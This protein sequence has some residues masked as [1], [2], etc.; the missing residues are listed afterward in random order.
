MKKLIISASLIAGLALG[1]SAQKR[2]DNTY[3]VHNY[4]QPNKARIAAAL[5]LDKNISHDYT[6]AT[7][8]Y[9]FEN[10]YKNTFAGV[11]NNGGVLPVLPVDNNFGLASSRNYKTQF[12]S[13]GNGNMIQQQSQEPIV[14]NLS[15]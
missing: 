5:N 2:F 12:K 11:K 8:S 13:A 10:N 6:P 9:Y 15:E 14:L 1:A 3:S 7:E 4:K